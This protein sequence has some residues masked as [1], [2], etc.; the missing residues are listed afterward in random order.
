MEIYNDKGLSLLHMCALNH[1]IDAA[2]L[3]CAHIKIYGRGN[4]NDYG[5]VLDC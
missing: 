1:N 3:F 5:Q 4:K 2:K